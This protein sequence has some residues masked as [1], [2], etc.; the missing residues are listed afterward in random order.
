VGFEAC[1]GGGRETRVEV[2]E[3]FV[4]L[5]FGCWGV[6]VWY[7][8]GDGTTIGGGFMGVVFF[9]RSFALSAFVRRKERKEE[10]PISLLLSILCYD[11]RIW[12]GFLVLGLSKQAS[13]QGVWSSFSNF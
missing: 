10:K 4:L 7:G 2:V 11:L 1:A 5:R 3:R 8:D 12:R 13:K 9:L 6:C